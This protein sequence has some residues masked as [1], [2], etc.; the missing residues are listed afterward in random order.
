M[1]YE[2]FLEQFCLRY[3][4]ITYRS[5]YGEMFTYSSQKE[6]NEKIGKLYTLSFPPKS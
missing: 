3:G 4:P 2:E 5:V 1:T 6:F